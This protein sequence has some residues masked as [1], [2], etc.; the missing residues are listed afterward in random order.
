MAAAVIGSHTCEKGQPLSS[1]QASSRCAKITVKGSHVATQG[2]VLKAGGAPS[3]KGHWRMPRGLRVQTCP[4][5]SDARRTGKSDE[6]ANLRN[7]TPPAR[8]CPVVMLFVT[9]GGRVILV[10]LSIVALAV[11]AALIER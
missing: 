11:A 6:V 9:E 3:R 4:V 10:E 2:N 8:A 1:H 7:L 5:P